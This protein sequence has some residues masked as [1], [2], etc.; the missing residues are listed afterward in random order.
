MRRLTRAQQLS[1]AVAALEALPDSLV[2]YGS[3]ISGSF[4][5]DGGVH[6]YL[7]HNAMGDISIPDRGLLRDELLGFVRQ[8][9]QQECAFNERVASA[10]CFMPPSR[11]HYGVVRP[12]LFVHSS[13][14]E[15]ALEE[16]LRSALDAVA[17][18]QPALLAFRQ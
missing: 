17:P 5:G 14:G 18:G 13:V 1:N 12:G 11:E 16:L 6:V 15:Q 4:Y 8:A 10:L 2:L 3:L 7:P 9:Q